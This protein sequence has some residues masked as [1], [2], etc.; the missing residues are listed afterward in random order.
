MTDTSNFLSGFFLA[1]DKNDPRVNPQ[2]RQRLALA[3][4]AR[5]RKYPKNL[6]EGIAAVGANFADAITQR[7]LEQADIAQQ[8]QASKLLAPPGAGPVQGTPYAPPSDELANAPAVRAIDAATS[9]PQ[10]I[11]PPAPPSAPPP[12]APGR[13][14][15]P[16]PMQPGAG[17]IIDPGEYNAL[18]AADPRNRYKPAPAYLAPDLNSLIKDP[19]RRGFLGQLAGK[20]AQSPNEISPTG[21]A[22]PFQFTRGTGAQYGVPG[23]AR[24]DPKASILAADRLTDDNVATLTAKLG[25][26]PTPGEMALAHQQGAGTAANML[27]GAGNAP[28]QNLAV[29]NVPPGMAPG[30]AA[31][32]IMGYYGMPGP[33]GGGRDAV[34]SALLQ[35]QQPP[36]SGRPTVADYGQPPVLAFTGADAGSG[37]QAAPP[38][39]SGIRAAPPQ[40]VA[41]EQPQAI[42]GYVPPPPGAPQGAPIVRPDP[43]LLR[44]RALAATPAVQN[45]GYAQTLLKA[46]LDPLETEHAIKQNAANEQYKAQIAR[47]TE[48]IKMREQARMTQYERQQTARKNEQGIISGDGGAA[49]TATDPRLLG[50]PQ[51]PQRTGIPNTPPVPP[52]QSQEEWS[53]KQTPELVKAVSAVEKAT[54]QFK[55]MMDLIQQ[56]ENHPGKDWAVGPLSSVTGHLP[57]AVGFNK[58][59]EQIGGQN[60]LNVYQQL[61]GGGSITEIEGTKA[62]AAQARLSTAQ[63]KQ[64]FD[65]AMDDFKNTLRQ[66]LETAQRKVNQP[67][68]A[69]QKSPNDEPAP[70]INQI[71][72]RKGKPSQYIGGNPALDSSYR[73]PR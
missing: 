50:T 65:K 28:A 64:D 17:E 62:Q 31:Q 5:D 40:Q 1:G 73:D 13:G 30:A 4:L 8:D 32:K 57:S 26:E 23:N 58:I 42:P 33:V 45:N 9:Q 72:I 19:E 44:L 12:Q 43:E 21:A 56:A 16:V 29:N 60:F 53:K 14:F 49:P 35:Q 47:D 51:S 68:T 34:A 25:R 69:W 55:Q 37:I 70:D 63:N 54:P 27:T 66:D 52:G 61:K 3:M 59:M 7:Q 46:K 39:P 36:P 67:V 11:P 71:G 38:A 15:T 22:G 2:L 41:Q 20:E 18:D 48:Q 10:V 6:G 24:L